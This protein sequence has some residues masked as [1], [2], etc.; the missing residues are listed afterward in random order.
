VQDNQVVANKLTVNA[1][2]GVFQQVYQPFNLKFGQAGAV[3]Q[4]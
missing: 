3:A 1:V 4:A 2:I